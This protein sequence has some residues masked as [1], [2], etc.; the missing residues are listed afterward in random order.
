MLTTAEINWLVSEYHEG[1]AIRDYQMSALLMA[2]CIKGMNEKE[3]ADLTRAMIATGETRDFS[4]RLAASRGKLIV[5]KHS[6]GGVGDK[7]SMV[8]VPLAASLGLTVPHHTSKGLFITGG[9]ADKIESIPNVATSLAGEK[10]DELLSTVGCAIVSPN[11]SVSPVENRIYA[12]RDTSGSTESPALIASSIMSKK[13]AMMP[14]GLLLD[15][16]TGRGAFMSHLKDAVALARMMVAIGENAKVKTRALITSMEQPLGVAVGNFVE[17]REAVDVLDPSAPSRRSQKYMDNLRSVRE[18]ALTQ[19]AAMLCMSGQSSSFQ[20]AHARAERK[21]EDGSAL[22]LF[23]HMIE[24]QGGD[25]RV[26]AA[27]DE[28]L[29]KNTHSSIV[30]R[31]PRDG[32]IKVVDAFRVGMSSLALGCGRLHAD[33]PIDPIAGIQ[34]HVKVGDVVHRGD[35]L[36]TVSVGHADV[37]GYTPTQR[38][39]RGAKRAR[40]AIAMCAVEQHVVAEPLILYVVDQ[41]DIFTYDPANLDVARFQ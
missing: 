31:A 12:L 28:H 4:E 41:H 11:K 24:M 16:K 37:P 23:G 38:L 3:A 22:D 2:I 33:D 8:V 29:E 39:E 9:T 14:R 25:P 1:G 19:V 27:C 7:V 17:V 26:L 10:L 15:V 6:T 20:E 40:E 36:M 5:D 32:R 35:A 18:L 30:V 13:L 21:L 34:V